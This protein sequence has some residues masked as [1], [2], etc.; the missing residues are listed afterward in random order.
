MENWF[1]AT[2]IKTRAY[3]RNISRSPIPLV[4]E[5]SVARA[6]CQV[7]VKSLFQEQK[8]FFFAFAREKKRMVSALGPIYTVRLSG[9]RQA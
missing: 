4:S 9:M 8:H 7:S 5:V 1:G 2:Q 6:R 3:I